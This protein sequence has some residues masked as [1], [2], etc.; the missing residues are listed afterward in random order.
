MTPA[1]HFADRLGARILATDSRL[2][3][4]CDPAPALFPAEL[5]ELDDAAA[6]A[7]FGAALIGAV[8]AAAAAVKF[9]SA[10]Y[11]RLGAA[12]V[13]TLVE[14]LALARNAGLVTILDVKRGDVGHTSRAYADAY[15]AAGAPLAADAVTVSPYLGR[16]TLDAF[17]EVAAENGTGLFVLVKTSNPS[18]GDIQDITTPAGD[19]VY[20]RVAALVAEVGAAFVGEAG[21]S[22][23]GAVVGATYP[24]EIGRLRELMPAQFFLL[25]G[26]GAQGADVARL[27]PAFD[28]R[29]LGALVAASRSV[30]GAWRERGGGWPEAAAAAARELRDGVNAVIRSR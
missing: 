24:D 3:V 1:R 13:S 30:A 25:P 27:G 18:A 5:K 6:T 20:E 7:K 19:K 15:L 23:V 12:G 29:G 11:E 17:A 9:Q 28:E 10:F 21:Y 4:G 2:C 26:V 22:A 16:D 14:H 8:A